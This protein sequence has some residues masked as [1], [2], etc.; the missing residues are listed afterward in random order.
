VPYSPGEL[1]AVAYEGGKEI[2]TIAFTTAGKA[3]KLL[4]TPDRREMDAGRDDLSYVMVQVVDEQGRL[5]PDAVAPVSFAI[6]GEGE[7]AAVGN[8]D[9]KDVASFRRPHRM[10]FHGA[11]LAVI[12]PTGKPGTIELRADSHGLESATVQLHVSG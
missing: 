6:N 9:P 2:G 10:T 4:L 8:A 12:R 1:K 5:A 11:C 3:H 7:I